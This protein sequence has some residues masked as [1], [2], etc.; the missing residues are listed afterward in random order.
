MRLLVGRQ[1]LIN[2]GLNG[3]CTVGAGV[4]YPYDPD[5]DTSLHREIDIAQAKSL[6]KK[7]GQENLTVQLLTSAVATGTTAMPTVLQQQAKAAGVTINMKPVNPTTFFGPNYLPC[8]SP[9]AYH[10]SSP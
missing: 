6:L 8:T 7:A 1:Q 2:K 9:H 10:L 3:F 4:A 5:Y